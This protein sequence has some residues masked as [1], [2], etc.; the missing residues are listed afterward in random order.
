MDNEML[1]GCCFD[2]SAHIQEHFEKLHLF[3]KTALDKSRTH[4]CLMK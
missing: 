2:D 1:I 3:E 4:G